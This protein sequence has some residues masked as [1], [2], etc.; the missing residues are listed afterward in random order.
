MVR[1]L[2]S[3]WV[4][5]PR[6]PAAVGHY[7]FAQSGSDFYILSGSA[8]GNVTIA[9]WRYNAD[10]DSWVSLADVP[11]GSEAPAAAYLGGKIF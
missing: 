7:G 3:S 11:V 4:E 8:P 6:I 5:G 2:A 10:S 9:C 1:A